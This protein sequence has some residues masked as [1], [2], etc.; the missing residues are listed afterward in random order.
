MQ[1]KMNVNK[2]EVSFYDGAYPLW[3][4]IYYS[5]DKIAT[6]HHSELKD[7]EYALG[8]VREQQRKTLPTDSKD[9]A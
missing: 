6:I 9:E 5:G 2:F 7:L 8:R 1:H 3:T 4:D